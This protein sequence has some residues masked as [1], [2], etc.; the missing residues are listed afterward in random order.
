MRKRNSRKRRFRRSRK[1]RGAGFFNTL[2]NRVGR[3]FGSKQE[4][5]P[6]PVALPPLPMSRQS[7]LSNVNMNKNNNYVSPMTANNYGANNNW[8]VVNKNTLY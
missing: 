1:Q 2:K 3:I 7:S 6:V 5:E 4:H 8:V